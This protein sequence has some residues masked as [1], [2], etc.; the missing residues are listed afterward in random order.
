MSRGSLPAYDDY[1]GRLA[2]PR[3]FDMLLTYG[4]IAMADKPF[5]D[6]IASGKVYSNLEEKYKLFAQLRRD[7]P[8][9][10]TEPEGYRPFWTVTKHADIINIERQN[11]RFLNE[12]RSRLV[13][14][15]FEERVRELMGGRP[16]L[17]QSMHS[18]DSDKHKAYRQITAS[19]FMPKQLKLLDERISELAR[20]TVDDL[21]ARGPE[22][23]FYKEIA[24]WYPLKVIMLILGLP[25]AD[26]P[27]LQRL[28]SAY[29]GGGDPEQQKGGDVIAAAQAFREY[30]DVVS[31]DRR[32]HLTDDVASL[33]ANAVVGGK[34]IEDYLAS[35]YY[36]ALAGAGHDTTS[37]S[38]AGGVLALIENPDQWK[39][40]QENPK[41]L[42]T[43][44][45]EIIRWVSPI[46]HFFRTAA[47]DCEVQGRSV[48]AGQN[49][50]MVYPSGNRDEEAF[51]DPSS[52]RVDRQ[53]N[54]HLGFGFG[55]HMCLGMILAKIEMEI[56]FRE[57]LSRV[58]YF[59]LNGDP[60]W[61]ETTFVGGLKRLPV[62]VTMKH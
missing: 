2:V 61:V 16:L 7:D 21:Q 54:R 36:I 59:E 5:D 41:L 18:M 40:L 48:K 3:A 26:A 45:D 37:A 46:N 31:A 9:H 27:H 11:D 6:A 33:I 56:L 39:K 24:V 44:I 29:F 15:E 60:A 8:V 28:T 14:I 52:F 19:W 13:T 53:P 35:S 42:G 23:D 10:W 49:L 55:V 51:D 47:Q 20:K 38:T 22:C 30:F 57:L 50:M 43:A 58:S 34:P 1:I 12:P 25:D 4:D 17:V 32:A 62:R